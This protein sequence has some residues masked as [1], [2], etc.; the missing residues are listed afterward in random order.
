MRYAGTS[1]IGM[2]QLTDIFALSWPAVS[3]LSVA[4]LTGDALGRITERG[5]VR[6]VEER[7][8][9]VKPIEGI[10]IWLIGV[11]LVS[12]L[13]A[14]LSG[15]LPP[16]YGLYA[17]LVPLTATILL[18]RSRVRRLI[19][20]EQGLAAIGVIAI[21]GAYCT[22]VAYG[23]LPFSSTPNAVVQTTGGDAICGNIVTPMSRGILIVATDKSVNFI[24][25]SR[26]EA[27]RSNTA[28][29]QRANSDA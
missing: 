24:E 23:S 13:G 1:W 17:I 15:M 26:V 6:T 21:S 7:R 28:C 5:P 19:S 9:A 14:R 2:F 16:Q 3:I 22:G 10:N 11:V 18:V 4:T 27:V 20:R 25:W 12:V 8:P 29:A